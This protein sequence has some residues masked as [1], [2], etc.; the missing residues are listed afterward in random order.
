MITPRN[1]YPI[2]DV[3]IERQTETP[4]EPVIEYK[5]AN[6]KPLPGLW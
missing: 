2:L 3:D 5:S 1:C 4:A 6:K